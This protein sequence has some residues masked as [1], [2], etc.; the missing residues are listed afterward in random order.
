MEVHYAEVHIIHELKWTKAGTSFLFP[1]ETSALEDTWLHLQ[2]YGLALMLFAAI[3]G[4]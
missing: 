4:V 2:L 3:D 1:R